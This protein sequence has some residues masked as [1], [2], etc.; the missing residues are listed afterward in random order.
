M[1]TIVKSGDSIE[2]AKI[3]G[4]S[5][6]PVDY[7]GII[8]ENGKKLHKFVSRF[9]TKAC[10][11]QSLSNSDEKII[12]SSHVQKDDELVCDDGLLRSKGKRYSSNIKSNAS[13]THGA[14]S[15]SFA[16]QTNVMVIK[17]HQ[18]IENALRKRISSQ[19]ANSK[20]IS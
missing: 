15:W 14:S 20:K 7:K 3:D 5:R 11:N 6:K 10:I 19:E 8:L 4:S 13:S 12:K 2:G 17:S 1:S 9:N 16:Q 18:E